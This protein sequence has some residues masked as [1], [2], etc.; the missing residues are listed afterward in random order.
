MS[1]QWGYSLPISPSTRSFR[2]AYRSTKEGVTIYDYSYMCPIVISGTVRDIDDLFSPLCPIDLRPSHSRAFSSLLPSHICAHHPLPLSS[3]PSCEYCS[4]DSVNA[5]RQDQSAATD[6]KT[7]LTLHAYLRG[8]KCGRISLYFPFSYP[9]GYVGSADFLWRARED[10][11]P[12]SE[13]E[14]EVGDIAKKGSNRDLLLWI[15]PSISG[16]VM[17][18]LTR[19]APSG[20]TVCSQRNKFCLF[21]LRGPSSHSLLLRTI[22]PKFSLSSSPSSTA[23]PSPTLSSAW[24]SLSL[25]GSSSSLPS[26]CVVAVEA[27]D[28]RVFLPLS[29]SLSTSHGH[30]DDS[31]EEVREGVPSSSNLLSSSPLPSLSP[32]PS[33][34]S[35]LPV[36]VEGLKTLIASWPESLAVSRIWEYLTD[37]TK[38][39]PFPSHRD[40]TSQREKVIELIRSLIVSKIIFMISQMQI[41]PNRVTFPA[42]LIQ[43]PGD[44][45][46]TNKSA[47]GSDI[48]SGWD[49]F[50][51]SE[52]GRV[53]WI[54][55][56]HGGGRAIGD[57][58]IWISYIIFDSKVI[59]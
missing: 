37:V 39:P 32:I 57:S 20:V 49:I 8:T 54:A 5:S 19:S 43:R 24:S 23:S 31:K 13:E 30:S 3:P 38:S 40:V 2:A 18:L 45:R 21:Q 55:L 59:F 16:I 41:D 47:G 34:S 51:P 10:E 6:L 1:L 9:F 35:S 14:E 50:L 26:R 36:R 4:F 17:D 42:I 11:N 44:G 15:H 56:S 46:H 22:Q 7:R 25:L 27:E 29:L 33:S 58:P 28:P 12:I 48:G 52:W 53:L